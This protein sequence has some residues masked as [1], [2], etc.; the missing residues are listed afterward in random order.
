MSGRSPNEFLVLILRI[1]MSMG[2]HSAKV[3]DPQLGKGEQQTLS[4]LWTSI[5]YLNLHQSVL[6]GMPMLLQPRDYTC[7]PPPS[8][9]GCSNQALALSNPE[10]TETFHVLFER[11]VPLASELMDLSHDP[12]RAET[13]EAIMHCTA[14][15]RHLL[16]HALEALQISH[17]T[18]GEGRKAIMLD[19][20]FR[21]L[22]L[23]VHRPFAHDERVPLRYPL[24]YW[25]SLDCALAILVHQRDLWEAHPDDSLVSR[26]FARL[27]WPDFL[28]AALT[29]SLYLLRADSPLDP[30]PRSRY[31]GIPARAMLQDAL[32]SCRDIWQL[33]KDRNVC[34]SHAFILI[35]RV[36]SAL[37][38]SGCDGVPALRRADVET[39]LD[40]IGTGPPG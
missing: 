12:T 20:L 1:A 2:L 23:S 13:Y 5:I 10:G 3:D 22:L 16:L 27:F 9:N 11:A 35:D 14:E 39:A 4:I 15:A 33:E 8:I 30:P 21:R 34:H 28:V 31:G 37:E 17:P 29:L 6:T 26:S 32:R 40:A 38:E 25:T 18:T 24:S 36:V 7:A 19:I